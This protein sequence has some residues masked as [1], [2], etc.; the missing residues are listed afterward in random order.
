[1]AM[2]GVQHSA[3]LRHVFN[4][5][6]K[7]EDMKGDDNEGGPYSNKPSTIGSEGPC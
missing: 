6:A 3:L 7:K 2:P 1:M 4:F 5:V